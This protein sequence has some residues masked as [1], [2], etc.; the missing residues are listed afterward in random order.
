LDWVFWFNTERPHESIDDLTP[1]EVE[2]LH[3]RVGALNGTSQVS[4]TAELRDDA[5]LVDQTR[6]HR[7]NPAF[8]TRASAPRRGPKRRSA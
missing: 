6:L 7:R 1:I 2:H 5:S 4:H 3:Y 8:S